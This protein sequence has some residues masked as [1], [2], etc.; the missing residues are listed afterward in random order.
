M[1]FD[2]V[3]VLVPAYNEAETIGDVVAERTSTRGRSMAC[4]PRSCIVQCLGVKYAHGWVST[5]A[6][7]HQRLLGLTPFG[8]SIGTYFRPQM[9]SSVWTGL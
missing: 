6:F 5:V 9:A 1:D 2:D 3:C 7:G 8:Q 4:Q